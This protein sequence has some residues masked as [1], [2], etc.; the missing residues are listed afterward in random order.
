M[1][2]SDIVNI[3]VVTTNPGITAPGFGI[4]LLLSYSATWVERTRTYSSYAGVLSDFAATTPEAQA[5]A[6]YFGQQPAPQTLM[7]GRGALPPTTTWTI[8]LEVV[9][10]T[11][12][13]YK[14]RIRD[15]VTNTTFQYTVAPADT[16]DLIIA[17]LKAAYDALALT[18]FTSSIA[19]GAGSH[20]LVLAAA[21]P[22]NWI[23][24]EVFDVSVG[25]VGGLL[26]L[27]EGGADPGVATDLAAVNNESQ[28][29]YGLLMLFKSQAIALATATWV[30]ANGKFFDVASADTAC[31][32]DADSGATD[33]CHQI[34]AAARARTAADFHPR[35][36]EFFD[37]AKV[38]RW[39]PINPG[40]D[41]WRLK[42]LSGPTP[43]KFTAT[44]IVNLKAKYAGW[45]YV[46][47]AGNSGVNVVGGDGKVGANEYIDVVRFIDWY[48]INL[49]V[50]LFNV[51]YQNEKVPYTDGGI[52]TIEAAIRARN[53][54][55]ILAGGIA[56]TP[57]PT[58]L[59]PKAANVP[60]SDKA[61][62]V[63]NNVSTTWTLAGALNTLNPTVQVLF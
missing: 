25:A 20:V 23:G 47:G 31:A 55:G 59:V 61:N 32:T 51:L 4:A 40:R 6:T 52:A 18:H 26:K 1:P 3:T 45:Y 8:A 15:G 62:R 57:A 58:V 41:N 12:T 27:T 14:V 22:A 34:K 10:A 16:N 60:T 56:A 33:T 43:V 36:D 50:D 35:N 28:A 21:T 13:V 53:E 46:I 37:V 63:L 9:A 38:G 2:L 29:W 7:I 11:G 39:F 19:G 48:T 5:A 54:L 44:Q 24:I 42:T 17:G 30:E 49:Q